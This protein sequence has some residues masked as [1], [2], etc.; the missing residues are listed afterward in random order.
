MKTI[1]V[2]C[3][4]LCN[5]EYGKLVFLYINMYNE[6]CPHYT[7]YQTQIHLQLILKTNTYGL[8]KLINKLM[9]L[10]K[11]SNYKKYLTMKYLH[12]TWQHLKDSIHLIK[13]KQL[14]VEMYWSHFSEKHFFMKCS[15]KTFLLKC[16][17]LNHYLSIILPVWQWW[18]KKVLQHHSVQCS[19]QPCP[20]YTVY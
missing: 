4:H 20:H 2:H 12:F 8:W 6:P 13:I 11:M 14:T 16:I 5:R 3:M 10:L 1:C 19:W 9:D 18:K 17:R 15:I 7:I